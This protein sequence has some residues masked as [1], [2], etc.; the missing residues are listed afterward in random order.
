MS[1][2][3]DHGHPDSRHHR[4][5]CCDECSIKCYC[6]ESHSLP[7]QST[8]YPMIDRY[9]GAP[10]IEPL[11]LFDHWFC[12]I[13]LLCT[14]C[15]VEHTTQ[16]PVAGLA[17]AIFP[18]NDEGG[19]E[20]AWRRT[21]IDSENREAFSG[22]YCHQIL[23]RPKSW[24]FGQHS[25]LHHGY[26]LVQKTIMVSDLSQCPAG[27]LSQRSLYTAATDKHYIGFLANDSRRVQSMAFRLHNES[28]Y[29]AIR[30]S[31][32]SW[33]HRRTRVGCVYESFAAVNVPVCSQTLVLVTI[34]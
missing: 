21:W 4:S 25:A 22:Q 8:S 18:H 26:G 2:S 19:W 9:Y 20:E 5:G 7:A 14:L 16:L 31:H 30:I 13:C 23:P 10:L 33:Q 1:S 27:I 15:G 34:R 29:R 6:A 3:N 32:A 11:G 17:W 28:G 24:F 12:L